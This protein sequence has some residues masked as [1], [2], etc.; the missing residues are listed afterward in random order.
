VVKHKLEFLGC[1]GELVV[2]S[3]IGAD[4]LGSELLNQAGRVAPG[5]VVSDS[6]GESS[7]DEVGFF[8][9]MGSDE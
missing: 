7:V 4:A 5:V 6:A 1:D 8:A 2:A 9:S 3:A